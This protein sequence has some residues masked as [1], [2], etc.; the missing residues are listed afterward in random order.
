MIVNGTSYAENVYDCCY[1]NPLPLLSHWE[2]MACSHA[3]RHIPDL[4]DVRICKERTLCGWLAFFSS[5]RAFILGCGGLETNEELFVVNR[6][7]RDG[8]YFVNASLITFCE[9]RHRTH[10]A[11]VAREH[12]SSRTYDS[13]KTRR[14]ITKY[15][16]IGDV[17]FTIFE[18]WEKFTWKKNY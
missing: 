15:V 16:A 9:K 6:Y 4:D 11:I 10:R 5:E 17:F 8:G 14:I 12:W 13:R 18:L 1:F 2:R 3:Q 7:P